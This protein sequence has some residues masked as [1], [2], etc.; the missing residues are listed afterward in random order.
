MSNNIPPYGPVERRQRR[1]RAGLLVAV[2]RDARARVDEP[3]VHGE[4]AE[5]PPVCVGGEGA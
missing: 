5:E 1:V 2:P 3:V 4:E